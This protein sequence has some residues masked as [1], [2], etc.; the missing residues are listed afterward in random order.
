MTTKKKKT[1][2]LY[3]VTTKDNASRIIKEGFIAGMNDLVYF[4]NVSLSDFYWKANVAV[5]IIV[6]ISL[7]ENGDYTHKKLDDYLWSALGGQ[8]IRCYAFDDETATKYMT[9]KII[10][11]P[12]TIK[13]KRDIAFSL[14]CTFI[15]RII[16]WIER[17][18]RERKRS[19]GLPL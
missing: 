4:S 12:S 7:L 5:E 10:T 13:R 11:F 1:I 18:K 19:Q 9:G 3:H 17:K 2:A 14:A 6:P 15:G 8:Q 16:R